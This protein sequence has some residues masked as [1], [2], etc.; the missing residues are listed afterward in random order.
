VLH[1][2]QELRETGKREKREYTPEMEE[3]MHLDV[4]GEEITEEEG[5][6]LARGEIARDREWLARGERN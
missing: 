4:A 5:R 2:W 1:W 3:K 6:S